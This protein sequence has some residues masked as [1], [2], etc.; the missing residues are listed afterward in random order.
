M[1][2]AR[3]CVAP[4]ARANKQTTATT[5]TPGI[6]IVVIERFQTHPATYYLFPVHNIITNTILSVCRAKVWTCACSSSWYAHKNC[7]A[8]VTP[9]GGRKHDNPTYA[10]VHNV[11]ASYSKRPLLASRRTSISTSFWCTKK[12]HVYITNPPPPRNQLSISGIYGRPL[13]LQLHAKRSQRL[14]NK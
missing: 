7:A 13:A 4:S 12:E 8:L 14:L 11:F 10:Y 5:T 6:T 2:R 1:Q 9:G 3:T